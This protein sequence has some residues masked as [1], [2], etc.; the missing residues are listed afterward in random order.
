[1]NREIY[2]KNLTSIRKKF[3]AWAE[4]IEEKKYNLNKEI[5]VDMDEAITGETIFR[6]SNGGKMLYLNGRYNP[7][8]SGMDWLTDVNEI[9]DFAT[10]VIVGIHDGIHIRNILK[11]VKPSNN[12]LIYEP[13]IEVFIKALEEVDLSFLFEKNIP[14]GII[15]EGI[16]EKEKDSYLNE[17]ISYD[18][19]AML[20]IYIS[21]NYSKL[22]T[23]NT[24]AF[25]DRIK[26]HIHGI[27][28]NWSTIAHFTNVNA[29]N[30]FHNCK[31]MY[32][33]YSVSSL[34][35]ILTADMPTII[36]SAGPSLNK[37]IDKLK[38][39]QGRA[40]IIATDTAMKPLLNAGIIPN[41]F[42]I[43]DGLKP[44][45]LF[46]HP[47]ISKVPMVAMNVIS[48]EPMEIHKGK[49]FYYRSNSSLER[50]IIERVRKKDNNFV[51][52]VRL[53]SGGSV[54]TC[55]YSLGLFMGSRT[56]IL[57]GQDLAMTGNRTHAD[58][59]FQDKMDEIDVNS[60]EYFE[61]ESIDGGKVFTRGDFKK[62]LDWFEEQIR[63][64]SWIRVIDATEGGAKIHGAE[65]MTLQEAIEKTC[66]KKFNV[67]YKVSRLPQMFDEKGKEE[68]LKV[69]EQTPEKLT[70]VLKKAESGIKLYEKL[71][72]LSQKKNYSNI[73]LQK[74]LKQIGKINHFMEND[75][76]ANVVNDST[77]GVE[78]TLR[79]TIY[80][81]KEDVN[82]ELLDIAKNGKTMLLAMKYA[83]EQILEL[84]KETV[85]PF[86]KKQHEKMLRKQENK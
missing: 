84:S 81:N 73:E 85:E 61:V 28:S 18:N 43:V 76:M 30:V 52:M 70:Q 16:N 86:V 32:S 23:D 26:K 40:N 12:I 35:N 65:V 37:N 71:E 60:G 9:E 57:V 27:R 44:G 36:V 1:M 24:V 49:K 67:R 82:E 69:L 45:I 38:N 3:E 7:A 4:L 51:G 59:T 55:A 6:V 47:D 56:I 77:K 2:E 50:E 22:F 75:Y 48:T 54:A 79:A 74:L 25:V 72:K 31:Y 15:I 68:F 62:Y 33:G 10:I 19:M 5:C 58:G 42:I 20:K 66:I 78:L 8:Y 64:K 21:A 53:D 14:I 11:K 41:F 29:K 80:Q 46:E 83:A 63:M 17:M 39:A 13:S 34:A